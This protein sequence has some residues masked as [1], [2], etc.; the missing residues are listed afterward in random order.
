MQIWEPGVTTVFHLNE[1]PPG[2]SDDGQRSRA[3]QDGGREMVSRQPVFLLPYL[4]IGTQGRKNNGPHLT[5]RKD[6]P[7]FGKI[8]CFS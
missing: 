6:V 4:D 8:Y 7:P 1:K 3:L 2:S 5:N